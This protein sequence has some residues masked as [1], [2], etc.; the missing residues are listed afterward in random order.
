MSTKVT[1]VNFAVSVL[2]PRFQ[3][4]DF[5]MAFKMCHINNHINAAQKF[6]KMADIHWNQTELE[7]NIT[8]HKQ[9]KVCRDWEIYIKHRTPSYAQLIK[10]MQKNQIFVLMRE[11][12]HIPAFFIWQRLLGF[13]NF[14]RIKQK[15]FQFCRIHFLSSTWRFLLL[16]SRWRGTKC[17][18]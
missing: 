17:M 6:I 11:R 12:H 14:W 9:Y 7:K 8:I 3:S 15:H 1:L 16:N 13:F 10:N 4:W 5:P 18:N 2:I